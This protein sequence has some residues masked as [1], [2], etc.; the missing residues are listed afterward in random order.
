MLQTDAFFS[1]SLMNGKFK[2]TEFIWNISYIK[3]WMS[4]LI[5]LLCLMLKSISFKAQTFKLLPPVSQT[6]LKPS[7]RLKC[8]SELFQLKETCDLKIYQCLCF[9]SRCTTEMFF[10]KHFYKKS[11]SKSKPCLWNRALKFMHFIKF[12]LYCI[13]VSARWVNIHSLGINPMI[14]LLLA[15]SYTVWLLCSQRSEVKFTQVAVLA[16]HHIPSVQN[17]LPA[18]RHLGSVVIILPHVLWCFICG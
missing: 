2:N 5:S 10:P 16:T 6:R 4:L 1:G 18:D 15:L 12:T 13:K 8:K 14:L 3:L 11:K 17:V 9:V 7:P